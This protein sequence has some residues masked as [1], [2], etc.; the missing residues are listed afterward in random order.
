[1]EIKMLFNVFN[2]VKKKRSFLFI[3]VN[4]RT[5][6]KTVVTILIEINGN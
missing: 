5:Q 2:F 3:Y 6:L 1:M 4:E